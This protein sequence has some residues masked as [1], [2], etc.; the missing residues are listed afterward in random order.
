MYWYAPGMYVWSGMMGSKM[1]RVN[2]TKAQQRTA[3][4]LQESRAASSDPV[5]P[6]LHPHGHFPLCLLPR[7][8]LAQEPPQC[9]APAAPLGSH[10]R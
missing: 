6:P 8:P 9:L 1:L 3:R 2:G 7:H 5:N 10:P 4:A